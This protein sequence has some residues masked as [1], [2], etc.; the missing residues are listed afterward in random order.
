MKP[1]RMTRAAASTATDTA[2]STGILLFTDVNDIIYQPV[3][4]EKGVDCTSITASDEGRD[5]PLAHELMTFP[6]ARQGIQRSFTS[7]KAY[8]RTI[9]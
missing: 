3:Q 2:L 8:G 5:L 9:K 1:L 7:K 6:D 4:G